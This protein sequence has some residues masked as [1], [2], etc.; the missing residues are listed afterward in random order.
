[1]ALVN[2]LLVAQPDEPELWMAA[3]LSHVAKS[4]GALLPHMRLGNMPPPVNSIDLAV[5]DRPSHQKLIVAETA[6]ECEAAAALMLSDLKNL[7]RGKSTVAAVGLDTEWAP[8]GR[9]SV[10][11]L[12]SHQSLETDESFACVGQTGKLTV[13]SVSPC[14]FYYNWRPHIAVSSC[15]L[16]C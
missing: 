12:T 8:P 1:M 14:R 10:V 2:E 6:A 3:Q 13:L 4:C 9:E 16:G 15:D 5:L 7:G 11:G